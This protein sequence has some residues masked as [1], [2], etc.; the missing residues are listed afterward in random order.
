[1]KPLPWLLSRM[2]VSVLWQLASEAEEGR[3]PS[4]SFLCTITIITDLYAENMVSVH[5]CSSYIPEA[6]KIFSGTL[7]ENALRTA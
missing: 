1:M 3:S 6:L 4:A 7:N 5:P 2:N